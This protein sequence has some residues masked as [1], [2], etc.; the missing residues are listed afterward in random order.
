MLYFVNIIFVLSFFNFIVTGLQK[1][2]EEDE[3]R[4]IQMI[5]DQEKQIYEKEM[6]NYH[7]SYSSIPK[8]QQQISNENS[9]NDY[10]SLIQKPSIKTLS[11]KNYLTPSNGNWCYRCASPYLKLSPNLRQVVKNFLKIRRTS[12]PTDAIHDKCTKPTDLG[13]FKK[14]QCVSSYCQTIVL[15]DHD[16]GN[17]FTIRGCA[18]HFGAI[19]TKYLEERD[20][21]S[22]TKLHDNLEMYECICK[23]RKYCYAG[24]ERNIPDS[25]INIMAQKSIQIIENNNTIKN[26]NNLIWNFI[27]IIGFFMYFFILNE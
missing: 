5:K 9:Y 1:W 22:C 21:N 17:A 18:E 13:V 7:R 14:Q 16:T 2:T 3:A 12:Y 20:D 15:T 24:N 10:E 27:V 25:S 19:D 4:R 6:N 11:E 8:I 23:N 26:S